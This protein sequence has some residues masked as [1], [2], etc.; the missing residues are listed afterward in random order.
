MQR[1]KPRNASDHKAAIVTRNALRERA[2]IHMRHHEP[3]EHEEHVN[4]EVA[5]MDEVA[6]SDGIQVR[7]ALDAVMIEY[8][9]KRREP[10]QRCQ[11]RQLAV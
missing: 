11:R 7:K 10:A 2:M 1:V 4:G 3:A 8:D 6:V 5:F 9:P